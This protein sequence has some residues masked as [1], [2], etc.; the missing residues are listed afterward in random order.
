MPRSKNPDNYPSQYWQLLDAVARGEPHLL[1]VPLEDRKAVR[2]LQNSLYAYI[3]ALDARE[4]SQQLT[5]DLRNAPRFRKV[6][7]RHASDPARLILRNK[8]VSP[9]VQAITSALQATK[10]TRH[11]KPLPVPEVE[12]QDDHAAAISSLFNKREY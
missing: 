2:N 9:E 7:I 11:E 12:P 10:P 8:E 3:N 5:E 1:E 6:E 4:N